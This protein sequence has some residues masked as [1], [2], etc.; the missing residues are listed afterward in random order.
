MHMHTDYPG[1]VMR[2]MFVTLIAE[3][4]EAEQRQMPLATQPGAFTKPV[5]K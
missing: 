5:S 1:V 4:G 3:H 2:C